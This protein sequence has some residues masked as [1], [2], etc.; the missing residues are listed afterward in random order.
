MVNVIRCINA[1]GSSI[2]QN[3]NSGHKA[4]DNTSEI[5]ASLLMP[6]IYDTTAQTMR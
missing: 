6:N 1:L 3:W 4:S 2:L 5:M